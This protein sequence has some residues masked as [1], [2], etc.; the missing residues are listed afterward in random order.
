M[1]GIVY[2]PS[3]VL[4]FNAFLKFGY[5]PSNFSLAAIVPLVKNKSG[6]LCDAIITTEL[7]PCLTRYQKYLRAFSV[8][9][10]SLWTM[11]IC[12]SLVSAEASQLVCVLMLSKTLLTFTDKM[13]VM[14]FVV[15]L[16]STKHLTALT[17]GCCSVNCSIAMVLMSVT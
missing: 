12:I 10:L 1:A 4:L 9:I 2:G 3:C 5:V 8:T 11:L 7:L 13:A 15:L 14:Y 16:I 17:T 6:D